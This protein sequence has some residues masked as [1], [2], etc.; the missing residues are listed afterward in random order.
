ML[1]GLL[2]SELES[3]SNCPDCGVKPGEN[4]YE[5]CDAARC[6]KTG[7]QKLSCYCSDC[8]NQIWAGLWSGV[9]QCYDN[10]WVVYD[11]ACQAIMFD[12][13]KAVVE[14]LHAAQQR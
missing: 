5:G 6:L 11:D 10:G 7:N 13:N 2:Q 4:H 3:S 14:S 1:D 8:G 9:Q 12:V